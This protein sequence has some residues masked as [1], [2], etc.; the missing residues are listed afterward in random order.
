[1]ELTSDNLQRLLGFPFRG[2]D[3]KTRLGIGILV[4]LAGWIVPVLPWLVLSGYAIQIARQVAVEGRDPELPPWTDW[5]TYLIDGFKVGLARFLMSLPLAI[6]MLIAYAILFLGTITGG[7]LGESGGRGAEDLGAVIAVLSSV[8]GIG[9]FTVAFPI[10]LI[11][12]LIVPVPTMHVAITGQLGALFRFKEWWRLLRADTGAW[13]SGYLVLIGLGLVVNMATG[14]AMA[15]VLL[16]LVIPV[17]MMAYMTYALLIGE[18]VFAQAYRRAS[19]KLG[20]TPGVGSLSVPPA[21][22]QKELQ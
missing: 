12:S 6:V 10:L 14:I 21:Q 18:V 16:C 11:V 13:A 2:P 3:W 15:T 8:A 1:M 5:T 9:L 4:A 22:T 17:L 7:I 19:L 20:L